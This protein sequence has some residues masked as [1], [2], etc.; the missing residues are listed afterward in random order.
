MRKPGGVNEILFFF[1]FFVSTFLVLRMVAPPGVDSQ[2]ISSFPYLETFDGFDLCGDNNCPTGSDCMTLGTGATAWV[3]EQGGTLNWAVADHQLAGC[4]SGPVSG[5]HTGTGGSGK[6]LWIHQ[7]ETVGC[8]DG[9][10]DGVGCSSFFFEENIGIISPEFSF[11]GVPPGVGIN[12][13]YFTYLHGLRTGTMSLWISTEGATGP[14]TEIHRVPSDKDLWLPQTVDL[15]LYRGESSVHLRFLAEMLDDSG[16]PDDGLRPDPDALADQALDDV[17]IFLGNTSALTPGSEDRATWV[18]L[19]KRFPVPGSFLNAQHVA[20]WFATQRS[21]VTFGGL[22]QQ[23]GFVKSLRVFEYEPK[24]W[25]EDVELT[26]SDPLARRRSAA[27]NNLERDA[28]FLYGGAEFIGPVATTL[29][30]DYQARTITELSCTN[31]DPTD[32]DPNHNLFPSEGASVTTSDT[33]EFLVFG[34]R[35]L[36][37]Q[38]NFITRYNVTMDPTGAGA[39]DGEGNCT[40]EAVRASSGTPPPRSR[41]GH[42][43]TF[44]RDPDTGFGHLFGHGG[45]FQPSPTDAPLLFADTF[46]FD[47]DAE[48]WLEL[49]LLDADQ[50]PE[51]R[52]FHSAVTNREGDKWVIYGGLDD[53]NP[54]DIVYY[55]DVFVLI[56]DREFIIWKRLE[57]TGDPALARAQHSMVPLF[58]ADTTLGALTDN[59]E[60]YLIFG[61][62]TPEG[63]AT[64]NVAK[65]NFGALNLDPVPEDGGDDDND[66]PTIAIVLGVILP[67]CCILLLL[68]LLLATLLSATFAWRAMIKRR[69]RKK[70]G[71]GQEGGGGE[72]LATDEDIATAMSDVNTSTD[73]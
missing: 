27:S 51:R 5:D 7:G 49:R 45:R 12:L 34:G 20:G 70:Y 38:L 11:S 61:G 60:G 43:S 67:F 39:G 66:D 30:I 44:W 42:V 56:F 69:I 52:S 40:Y 41:W 59:E 62:T 28:M 33:G 53:T 68:V 13:R 71:V 18:D 26:E 46:V 9:G 73:N 24:E 3:Q 32:T 6:Y 15:S 16:E 55:S 54:T 48:E 23:G 72:N 1:A 14:W 63:A 10:I 50:R 2:P 29:W 37:V 58:F 22:N 47:L 57:A 64:N 8:D 31:I 35:G 25:T 4:G 36:V 17:N 19:S 21:M 65:L